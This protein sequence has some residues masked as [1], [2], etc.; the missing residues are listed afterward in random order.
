MLLSLIFYASLFASL[1]GATGCQE[2]FDKQYLISTNLNPDRT[3]I[4][5]NANADGEETTI[6]TSAA[7]GS[8]WFIRTEGDVPAKI[9][10]TT[11][12]IIVKMN[13]T[14][15][16]AVDQ[17]N[18]FNTKTGKLSFRKKLRVVW[19]LTKQPSM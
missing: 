7:K 8:T 10:Q 3:E 5:F 13:A 4:T 1:L 11:D 2:D 16:D 17:D 6:M 18:A 9:L 12:R 19:S 15:N 14:I